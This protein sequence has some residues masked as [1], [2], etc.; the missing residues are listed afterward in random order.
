MK[1]FIYL[2]VVVISMFISSCSSSKAVPCCSAHA[3]VS[4]I[5][6]VV[7]VVSGEWK[8]SV[9]YDGEDKL[10]HIQ[11]NEIGPRYTFFLNGKGVF[12]VNPEKGSS[13]ENV[14]V[15]HDIEWEL[16]NGYLHLDHGYDFVSTEGDDVYK[17]IDGEYVCMNAAQGLV[18]KLNK[19]R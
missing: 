16:I 15:R 6:T 19:V 10:Q 12:H 11:W 13:M 4:S 1:R 7:P 17:W 5:D 14:I 2:F 18:V 8:Q 3:N 9:Y